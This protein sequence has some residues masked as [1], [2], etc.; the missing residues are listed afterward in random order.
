MARCTKKSTNKPEKNET[1]VGHPTVHTSFAAH[2]E[3]QAWCTNCDWQ[4]GAK[5]EEFFFTVDVS[6]H[7]TNL[8]KKY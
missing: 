1:V 5:E 3:K 2:S 4:F 8:S 6:Q 7:V